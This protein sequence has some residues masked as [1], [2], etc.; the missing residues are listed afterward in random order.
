MDGLTGLH[1]GSAAATQASQHVLRS[2]EGV[3]RIKEGVEAALVQLKTGK[4]ILVLDQP[5]VL[6]A[7][8]GD[9]VGSQAVQNLILQL[10][11]VCIPFPLR[12]WAPGLL[13]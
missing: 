6:L 8:S 3:Q 1:T 10:R 13:T 12:M 11:E 4:K 5:D 2:S 7:T 9:D